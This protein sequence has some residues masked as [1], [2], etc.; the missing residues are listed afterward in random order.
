[1]NKVREGKHKQRQ[2]FNSTLGLYQGIASTEASYKG[3]YLLGK[4]GK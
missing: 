4:N 2:F 3:A 1:M